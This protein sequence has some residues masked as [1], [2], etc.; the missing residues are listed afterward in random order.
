MSAANEKNPLTDSAIC[1]GDPLAKALVTLEPMPATISRDELMFAAGAANRDRAVTFWKRIVLGQAA[2]MLVGIGIATLDVPTRDAARTS[3]DN[4]S[5]PSNPPMARTPMA[6]ATNPK[7]VP[8][9]P[10]ERVEPSSNPS[11]LSAQDAEQTFK[12][13]KYLQLRA[14]VLAMGLHVLPNS[15][16]PSATID[17]GSLEDS[18]QLP[19]GTFAIHALPTKKPI[20]DSDE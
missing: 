6:P 17:V 9:S 16:A 8:K 12:V 18:L 5:N 14:N 1:T 4:A 19:R 10:A 20:P 11:P 7:T 3:A 15:T 2:C 13:A